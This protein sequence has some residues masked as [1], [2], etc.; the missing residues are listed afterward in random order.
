MAIQLFTPEEIKELEQHPAVQ[1]VNGH[2]L[3]L[4]P[5]FKEWF[6]RE[7]QAGESAR[8]ILLEAGFNTDIIKIRVRSIRAHSLKWKSEQ[9]KAQPKF[10]SEPLRASVYELAAA[11]KKIDKLERE[12]KRS[13]Q[14]LEFVKKI[15]N[16]G[17][18]EEM[19]CSSQLRQM[20]ILPLYKI[21]CLPMTTS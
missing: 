15:I 10:S 9:P 16:A 21:H 4:T 5:E 2:F 17:K 20:R 1:K 6:Y 11:H 19:E 18:E 12:L 13:K 14:E 7:F 3:H 8:I